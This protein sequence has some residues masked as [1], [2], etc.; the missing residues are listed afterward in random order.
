[1]LRLNYFV[2]TTDRLWRP[3]FRPISFI[4]ALLAGAATIE[5]Q[6]EAY[7]A[8]DDLVEPDTFV[9]KLTDP[10]MIQTARSYPRGSGPGFVTG[11][12]IKQSAAY[13]PPWSYYLDP[14]TITFAEVT[15]EAC[16]AAVSAIHWHLPQ[17]SPQTRVCLT[18]WNQFREISPPGTPL[19][20]VP[21]A[22]CRVV[23]TRGAAGP[24]GGPYLP[25]GVSRDFPLPAGN[26][27]IPTSAQAY[28][29]NVTA[30]PRGSLPYLTMWPTGQAPPA[31]S[32][33]NS[34]DGRVRANS[35]IVAAGA[36]GA[37]SLFAA[38]PTD[39]VLDINGYFTGVAQGVGLS[40]YP[41]SGRLQD[42]REQY[43]PPPLAAGVARTFS[44]GPCSGAISLNVTVIPK[45]TLRSLTL[46]P[47]GQPQPSVPTL[48][49]PASTATAVST[50]VPVTLRSDGGTFSVLAS[51][52]TDLVV[53]FNGC[54]AA[55]GSSNA[56]A[57]YTVPPCRAYDSRLSPYLVLNGSRDFP[58]STKCSLGISGTLFSLNA[59]VFP[60]GPLGWITIWQQMTALPATSALNAMDGAVTSNAA[61]VPVSQLGQV[62]VYA[63]DP[64]DLILDVTGFFAPEVQA[65]GGSIGA[66][67]GDAAVRPPR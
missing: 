13:N 6:T 10:A 16:Q 30:M 33:L 37:V 29:L 54:F 41:Q 1:M 63:T 39:V 23:D 65:G 28:V 57:F 2:T 22:P 24:L 49:A 3:P 21:M 17:Y 18:G 27:G 40:F 11:V 36:N 51:D 64:T 46:W 44:V 31:V 60:R 19:H 58:V 7:F 26:C 5:A 43:G 32:T 55:P 62:S 9:I 20:F 14:S 48:T 25:A 52:D 61:I 8:F 53:D 34:P 59:T 45:G 38:G 15:I 42:S 4:L 12:L 35:A 66:P 56:L 67:L 47:A 50:I